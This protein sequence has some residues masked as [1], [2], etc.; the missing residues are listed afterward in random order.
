M[1]WTNPTLSTAQL[2]YVPFQTVSTVGECY[3][4]YVEPYLPAPDVVQHWNE[5]LLAYVAQP[6]AIVFIRRYATYAQKQRDTLRRGFLTLDPT[7]FGYVYCDNSIAQLIFAQALSG[8]KPT[9]AELNA[10]IADRS[11]PVSTI[12]SGLERQQLT[13]GLA[14]SPQLGRRGWKLSHLHSVNGG[15]DFDYQSTCQ[16]LFPRGHYAWWGTPDHIYRLDSPVSP[17]DREKMVAHFLRTVHPANYFLSPGRRHQA[18]ADVGE[19]PLLLAFVNEQFQQRY[20][21]L[22][23]DLQGPFRVPGSLVWPAVTAST[24]LQL[25]VQ[26]KATG[27]V[28]SKKPVT[29]KPAADGASDP[30]RTSV[31]TSHGPVPITFEPAGEAA[32]KAA[33]LA[34]KQAIITLSLQDGS[35]RSEEWD[36]SNFTADSY[37]RGN[38]LSRQ[39]LRRAARTAAGVV[40][41]HVT[42]AP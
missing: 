38:L 9:L 30:V 28:A 21:S 32:F 41:I 8:R 37:L 2:P 19:N 40:A 10:A 13:F 33:L 31:S 26:A 16:H 42:L 12:L 25:I 17:D 29:V 20:G 34:R 4:A 35:S 27:K 7:G 1:A 6:Q 3:A 22:M 11:F 24:P 14:P 18:G 15:Y 39:S 5:L 23:T 36:A